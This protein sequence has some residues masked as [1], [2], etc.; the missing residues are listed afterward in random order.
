MSTSEHSW[1]EEYTW[2]KCTEAEVKELL[3]NLR[4]APIEHSRWEE[5]TWEKLAEAEVKEFVENLCSKPISYASQDD[6]Q[7]HSETSERFINLVLGLEWA[8][9]TNESSLNDFS[10]IEDSTSLEEKI[11]EVF[12]VDVSDIEDGNLLKIFERIDGIV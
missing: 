3:E 9:I 5:Y 12:G 4:S 7:A 6:I 11:K 10:L 1:R 2:E 8:L